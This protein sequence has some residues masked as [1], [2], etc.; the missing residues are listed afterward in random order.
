MGAMVIVPMLAYAQSGAITGRVT[1]SGTGQPV[2]DA[3]VVVAGTTRGART[4]AE[5]RYRI[6][7]VPAGTAQVR[8]LRIGYSS[9]AQTVTVAPGETNTADF[10]LSSAAIS[11]DRVL[12]TATG[13]E[14]RRVEVGN[15][16]SNIN[17]AEIQKAAVPNGASL[18]QGRAAGVT[19]IQNGGT[20][21]TSARVRI[22][23]ANSINLSNEPLLI[24]DNVR[25]NNSFNSYSI[26]TGGQSISRLND[27]DPDE[28]ENID[29]LKGPAASALY[30]TAAANGVIQVTTK[31][32]RSGKAIYSVYGETGNIKPYDRFPANYNSYVAGGV[33]PSFCWLADVATGGCPAFDSL[34]VYNPLMQNSPFRTGR[35]NR[36]GFQTSGGNDAAQY[37]VSTDINDETGVFLN[38]RLRSVNLRSNLSLVPFD[39]MR[40]QVNGGYMTSRASLPQNDNNNL[41]I[42][43]GGLLGKARENEPVEPASGSRLGYFLR[44]PSKLYNVIADQ[45]IERFTGGLTGNYTPLSWFQVLGTLGYD[46]LNRFDARLLQPNRLDNNVTNT[47]GN[48]TSNRYQIY[49]YTANIS[50][51][52]TFNLGQ[53]IVSKTSAGTQFQRENFTGNQAFG[54][55]LVAGTANLD[56]ASTG[57]AVGEDQLD[58]RTLGYFARQQLEFF[59]RIYLTG[60]LRGDKNSAF[61]RDFKFAKYPSVSLSYV[62]SRESWFPKQFISTFKLRGA[63]GVSGLRP[64]SVDALQFF[65]PTA[66]NVV[67]TET[68]AISIGNLGDL[69]LRPEKVREGE[70]GFESSMFGD[71]LGLDFTYFNKQSRDA[72]IRRTLPPGA[73]TAAGQLTNIGKVTNKGI[74]LQATLGLLRTE[75]FGW[76]AT[77]N[78]A[79]VKNNLEDLGK[80]LLGNDIE[81][82]IFGL[83]GASQRHTENRPLGAYYQTSYTYADANGDGIIDYTEVTPGDTA[84]LGNPLPTKTWSL[85]S[86]MTF[87]RNFRL[88]ALLDAQRGFYQYNTTEEFRC[89]AIANCAPLYIAGSPLWEQ[90][91]AIAN[92]NTGTG[93]GYIEEASYVKLRELSLTWDVPLQFASR[94]G[95]TR[96]LSITFAGRNLKTWT[97]YTGLDP[98]INFTTAN[99]TQ[100]EFLSQPPVKRFS[101]RI[102]FNF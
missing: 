42:V 10:A 32:G 55:T 82:I 25:V 5:G 40:I 35:H 73:G 57:F 24:I 75:R 85:N 38:N 28:I 60:A 1:E 22:R 2:A 87:F 72:L 54:T 46:A 23:G 98:E 26:G 92:I 30:G 93:A 59:E 31:R 89:G 13:G 96:G 68:A 67:G 53:S 88:S 65:N 37:F 7:D 18:L 81:P 100:A 27:L 70:V 39:K 58:N 12:V 56:G 91:R 66:V 95:I 51:T 84:F 101:T 41:G 74:E 77:L 4:D 97:D 90:A 62:V 83:G 86:T 94:M 63:Y 79:T 11:L 3:Q 33:N 16:V 80:D 61:G 17:V 21:G 102:N 14:Q 49:N 36:G 71:R 8:A 15:V 43:S 99:F 29:I 76:D 19:V 6:S 47:I 78:Y 69:N 48:R 64:G 52:A 20:T 44:A 34:F 50:G 9:A 45:D